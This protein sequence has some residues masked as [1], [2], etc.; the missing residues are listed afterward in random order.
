MRRSDGAYLFPVF[1]IFFRLFEPWFRL[2]V[3]DVF[4]VNFTY[5][6]LR[7]DDFSLLAT[8]RNEEVVAHTDIRPLM[9][10]IQKWHETIIWTCGENVVH[11]C[12]TLSS[13][14]TGSVV[15]VVCITAE[16][17]G[18]TVTATTHVQTCGRM[19]YNMVI[20]E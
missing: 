12:S 9:E 15:R 5:G 17:I 16:L 11:Y 19:P 20:L 7:S 6:Y 3:C 2:H 13:E 1:H 10:R 8:L 4:F 14:N 18:S